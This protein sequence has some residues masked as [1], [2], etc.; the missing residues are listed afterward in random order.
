MVWRKG[1][2]ALVNPQ[3]IKADVANDGT[4]HIEAWT[5]GVS[6]VPGVYGGELDPMHGVF[7]AGPKMALRPRIKELESRLGGTAVA[8]T[9]PAPIA[10]SWFPDPTSRHEL[11]YWDGTQWTATVA[12]GGQ[13]T[14]DTAGAS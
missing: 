4:V 5:A 12:D 11:R 10:A 3:F 13:S 1:F 8:A 7:G 14:T 2:G 6:L 9:A